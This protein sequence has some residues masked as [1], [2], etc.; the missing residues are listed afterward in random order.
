MI[1]VRLA[2]QVGLQSQEES[3]NCDN[4]MNHLNYHQISMC[5]ITFHIHTIKCNFELYTF[6]NKVILSVFYFA[7]LNCHCSDPYISKSSLTSASCDE[8]DS[9]ELRRLLL[10]CSFCEACGTV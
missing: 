9:P 4:K 8:T 6:K 5:S 1:G 10:F 3:G 7:S 2:G